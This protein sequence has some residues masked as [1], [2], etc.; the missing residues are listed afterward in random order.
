MSTRLFLY[1]TCAIFAALAIPFMFGLVPPNHRVGI[2]FAATLSNPT[3]W[4]LVHGIFGWAIC[5]CAAGL[6]YWLWRHPN[7]ARPSPLTLV[8]LAMAALVGL[9]SG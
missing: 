6:S 8:L 1:I 9:M 7:A 3:T 2:R 5:S 4:Y